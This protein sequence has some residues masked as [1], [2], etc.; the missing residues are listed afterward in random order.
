MYCER[1]FG[2]INFTS[3][4]RAVATSVHLEI[5]DASSILSVVDDV[6]FFSLC[7]EKAKPIK[8]YIR[9]PFPVC[10]I[11]DSSNNNWALTTLL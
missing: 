4:D 7:S 2:N 9:W 11:Y 3:F 10:G 6:D 5:M 8:C 1:I